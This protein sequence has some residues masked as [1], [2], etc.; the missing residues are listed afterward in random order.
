[1]SYFAY[2]SELQCT[3]VIIIALQKSLYLQLPDV[4]GRGREELE[5]EE[6]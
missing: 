1:M 2:V 3:V 5:I 6:K 4:T